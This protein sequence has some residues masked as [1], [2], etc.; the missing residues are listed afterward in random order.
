[1]HPKKT[2][3]YLAAGLPVVATPLPALVELAADPEVAGL[4]RLAA[5]PDDLVREAEF[6]LDRAYDPVERDRRRQV[7]AANSWTSR[8]RQVRDLLAALGAPRPA[9]AVPDQ[10][11]VA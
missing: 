3:E 5:T 10:E 1:V 4:V 7:A 9:S 8:G 11:V 6:A 2:Y